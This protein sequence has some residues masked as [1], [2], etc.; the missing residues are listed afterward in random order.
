MLRQHKT[1]TYPSRKNN[2]RSVK[3]SLLTVWQSLQAAHA[4][5]HN[6]RLFANIVFDKEGDIRIYDI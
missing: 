1:L 6:L 2:K 5:A 4:I 3:C